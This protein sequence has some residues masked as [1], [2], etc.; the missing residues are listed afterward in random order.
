MISF[1]RKAEDPRDFVIVACNFTPVVRQSYR[2]GVPQ[3]GYYREIFN[4]D[5]SFY[6]GS[7]VGNFPGCN[8]E[9]IAHHGRPTSLALTLPP[10]SVVVLKPDL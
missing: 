9:K 6:A 2:I 10:L 3:A 4:S 5:S 1:V 7:N 8:A